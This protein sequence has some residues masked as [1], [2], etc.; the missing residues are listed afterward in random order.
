MNCCRSSER[1][2]GLTPKLERATHILEWVRIEEFVAA[3]WCG[4]GRP[5]PERA[6]L[7]NAFAAKAVLGLTT[8]VGLIERLM[9]D[10]A[11]QRICGFPLHR[12]L[13]SEAAFSRAFAEFATAR[14]A[15]R[16]HE[17]L[18]Q[19][20]LGDQLIGRLSRDGTAIE[21]RERPARNSARVDAP[22]HDAGLPLVRAGNIERIGCSE[23]SPARQHARPAAQG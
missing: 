20:H 21:A 17:A 1:V 6:W 11:L 23:R 3:S 4:E 16:V 9:I 13:P 14:L 22:S 19:T 2:G 10:R 12:K 15:E 5:P 18:V 7:A 8:T